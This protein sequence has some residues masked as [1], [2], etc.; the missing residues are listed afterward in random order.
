MKWI[1]LAIGVGCLGFAVYLV[2]W[3]PRW[4]LGR[5]DPPRSTVRIPST[6]TP[7]ETVSLTTINGLGALGFSIAGGVSILGACLLNQRAKS[8]GLIDLA[9]ETDPVESNIEVQ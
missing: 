2:L 6:T 4:E 7:R 1:V 5:H 8:I 3:S 9:T